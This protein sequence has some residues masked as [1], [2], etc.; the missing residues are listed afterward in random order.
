LAHGHVNRNPGV[1]LNASISDISQWLDGSGA[2]A[3]GRFLVAGI[4]AV[5]ERIVLFGKLYN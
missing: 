3:H 1:G 5:D 2:S 4:A